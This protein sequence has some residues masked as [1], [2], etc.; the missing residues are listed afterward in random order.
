[1]TAAVEARLLESRRRPDGL[2]DAVVEVGYRGR[3]Y[4]VA[5]EK[6]LRPPGA[7]L[8]RLEGD[9]LLVEMRGRDGAPLA[10]CCIHR[11]HLEKGCL[12]CPSLLLPPRG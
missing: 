10:T 4:R 5:V 1:L 7:A 3:R 11:G 2:Y 8:A 9:Y 6:L 12:E